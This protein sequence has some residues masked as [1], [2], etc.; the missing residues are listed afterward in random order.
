MSKCPVCDYD[1]ETPVNVKTPE[2]EVVV[3]CDECAEK[4]HGDPQ[5]YGI[6]K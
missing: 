1:I 3:C 2:G 4:V 6:G 5:Q